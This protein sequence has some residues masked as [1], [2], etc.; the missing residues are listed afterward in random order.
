MDREE[1]IARLKD[2]LEQAKALYEG[3]KLNFD[4]ARALHVELGF[5]HPDGRLSHATRLYNYSLRSYRQALTDF[6]RFILDI[7]I[8]RMNS[9]ASPK[10]SALRAKPGSAP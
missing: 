9:G 3:S 2:A 4:Q 10:G 7:D 1:E 6:N 5:G 8:P